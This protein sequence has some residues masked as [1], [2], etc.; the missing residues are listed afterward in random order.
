MIN[1]E[2]LR[3]T[4][5]GDRSL[6]AHEHHHHYDLM[7]RSAL[8]KGLCRTMVLCERE[9]INQIMVQHELGAIR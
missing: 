5:G 9:T 6:Y 1:G 8:A 4:F 2:M 7:Y 3:E